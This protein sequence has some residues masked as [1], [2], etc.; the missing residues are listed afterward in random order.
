VPRAGIAS[1]LLRLALVGLIS[2]SGFLAFQGWLWHYYGRPDAFSAVQSNWETKAKVDDPVLRV[3]TLKSVVQ[4]AFR[5]IKFA[6]RGEFDLLKTSTNWNPLWNLC[7]L[8]LAVAGLFRPSGVPR[9]LYLLPILV[10][11]EA[12]WPDPY[13][14]DR[15]VGIGRYQLIAV[16]CFLLL[17]GWMAARWPALVRYGFCAGL[18]FLQCVFIR[19]FVNW[20][21]VG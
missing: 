7:I 5:P 14:G 21:L 20:I 11:L 19:D 2:I 9:L 12:W 18:L 16:P 10:F 17:A 15:L 4:P 13:R 8:M 3:L 1:T 6:L